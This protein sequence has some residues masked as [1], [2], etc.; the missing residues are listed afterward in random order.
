MCRLLEEGYRPDV[1][2]GVLLLPQPQPT[3]V[4]EEGEEEES[5]LHHR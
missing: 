4:E 3:Y 2:A 1:A 5:G